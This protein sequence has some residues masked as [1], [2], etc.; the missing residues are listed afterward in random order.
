MKKS[1]R[2]NE[3]NFIVRTGSIEEFFT[4]GKHIAKSLDKKKNNPN[5]RIISFE[6]PADLISF[7]TKTKLD[8][9]TALRK[10]PESITGLARKLHRSRSAI[11]RDIKML[12]SVG[13]VT[14]EYIS[15]SGHGRFRIIKITNLKP[16]RFMV[17]VT[18]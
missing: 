2:K 16:I 14:S 8:L 13:I 18:I 17:E 6:D 5:T 12:E 15:S 11:D 9:L 4:R 1:K 7:L 10:K 3:L